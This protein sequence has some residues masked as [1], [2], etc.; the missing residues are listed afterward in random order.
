MP[1]LK[2]RGDYYR[3]RER[4]RGGTK[5][6]WLTS[7]IQFPHTD[8][9]QIDLHT[10][11]CPFSLGL[12]VAGA[13]ECTKPAKQEKTRERRRWGWEEWRETNRKIPWTAELEECLPSVY[14]SGFVKDYCTFVLLLVKTVACNIS[15]SQNDSVLYRCPFQILTVCYQ[16]AWYSYVLLFYS[17]RFW[18]WHWWHQATLAALWACIYAKC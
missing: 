8:T 18:F 5:E 12:A 16:A 9:F 17:G 6:V 14:F 15:E 2:K 10:A 4:W 7:L 13:L 1:N 11:Q 3:R